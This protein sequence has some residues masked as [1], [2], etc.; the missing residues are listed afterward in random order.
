MTKEEAKAKISHELIDSFHEWLADYENLAENEFALKYGWGKGTNKQSD[1]F[2]SLKVF[3]EYVF[4]GRYLPGWIRQGYPRE[5]IWELHREGF[6]SYT[7]YS[8]YN[9]RMRGQTDWY[10]IPQRT[11]REIYKASRG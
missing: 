5:V 2:K 7:N 3:M 11:A 4:T 9:A 6:L 1:T 10:Y 8:N